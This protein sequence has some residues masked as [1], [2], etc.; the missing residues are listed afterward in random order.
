MPKIVSKLVI[1]S[2]HVF[3][4][5]GDWD[6]GQAWGGRARTCIQGEWNMSFTWKACDKL[7]L[8][9]RTV[10]FWILLVVSFIILAVLF[11]AWS[12]SEF[13]LFSYFINAL[14]IHCCLPHFFFKVLKVKIL[15]CKDVLWGKL[16]NK[17]RTNYPMRRT[18]SFNMYFENTVVLSSF[19]RNII[20]FV[21]FIII[22]YFFLTAGFEKFL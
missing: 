7:G 13:F 21:A 8:G 16:H 15:W 9:G 2:L 6:F 1:F 3:A 5:V 22:I 17:P 20:Y 11:S 19:L 12:A 10:W 18:M 4:V 14:V